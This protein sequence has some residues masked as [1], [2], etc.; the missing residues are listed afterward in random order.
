MNYKYRIMLAAV[1]TLLTCGVLTA[2]GPVVIYS[3]AFYLPNYDVVGRA[4]VPYGNGTNGYYILAN[5]MSSGVP[6]EV[7]I[8]RYIFDPPGQKTWSYSITGS[9]FVE[10]VAF[11]VKAASPAG[12]DEIYVAA[13]AEEDGVR[14]YQTLKFNTA[15]EG[16]PEN[17]GTLPI[18]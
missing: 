3:N 8:R 9:D 10:A 7:L 15:N 11:T 12:A 18:L 13:Y 5:G 2:Q 16:P 1:V 17:M 4:I 14:T 6:S